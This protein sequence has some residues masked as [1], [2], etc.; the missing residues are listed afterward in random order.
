VIAA[1]HADEGRAAA[2]FREWLATTDIETCQF[3]EQRLL[4]RIASRFPEKRLEVAERPRLNGV[5]RKLWTQARL[6]LSNATPALKKVREAGVE[7]LVL[8]GM[9]QAALDVRNLKG[10][11]AYDID[12]LIRAG[13]LPEAL[14]ILHADGWR[15]ARG[16]SQLFLRQRGTRFRSLNL[17]KPPFGD[18]DLHSRAYLTTGATS[19]PETGLWAR[20]ARTRLIDVD[21]SVPS[22]TDRLMNAI[23][24]GVP[25]AHHHSDWLADCAQLIGEGTVDWPLL[26]S[27][28][29]ELAAP[30]QAALVLL[31]V[32][33]VLGHPVPEAVRATLWEKARSDPSDYFKALLL[34]HPREKHSLVSSVGRRILKLRQSVQVEVASAGSV[35]GAGHGMPP[36]AFI[37]MRRVRRKVELPDAPPALRHRV[38]VGRGATRCSIV[39]GLE[40]DRARRHVFEVNTSNRHLARLKFRD[41]R[42][43]RPLLLGT[44]LSLPDDIETD[45]IWIEARPSGILPVLHSPAAEAEFAPR[46][47][48]LLVQSSG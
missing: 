32:H 5:V 6:A 37:K 41:L 21:V 19:A 20:S 45:D 15:S 18:I 42:G 22:P 13:D 31:Y 35:A 30:A 14:S 36:R 25:D 39:V 9:A 27:L 34:G 12:V 7:L 3:P 44:E 47:F 2:A 48:R 1:G 16:E 24:H 46:P 43:R 10:R 11:I 4:V 17:V 38:R 8:K 40:A 33:E 29:E 23:A 26:V 28:A